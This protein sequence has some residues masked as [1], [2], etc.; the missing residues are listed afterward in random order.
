MLSPGNYI[1]YSTFGTSYC[2]Q[3][4]FLSPL[5]D[6]IVSP[7]P[8]LNYFAPAH[9]VKGPISETLVEK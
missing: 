7:L 6:S 9:A 1:H 8:L 4:A 2:F 5:A 3:G